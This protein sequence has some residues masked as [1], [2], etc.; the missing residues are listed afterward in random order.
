MRNNWQNS[1]VTDCGCHV[2]GTVGWSRYCHVLSGQ[3]Q[4]RPFVNSRR[5]DEC[6]DG[7]Y[8]LQQHNAFGCQRETFH[9]V[10]SLSVSV[11]LSLS[12]PTLC[13]CVGWFVCEHE[14]MNCHKKQLNFV[15]ILIQKLTSFNSVKVSCMSAVELTTVGNPAIM[16]YVLQ[17]GKP[18]WEIQIN[19]HV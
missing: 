10:I 1:C 19:V 7:A 16:R 17:Q 13:F 15:V 2:E 4:C 3:C 14:L 5:C 9:H 12:V 18:L 11:S 6:V 8:N